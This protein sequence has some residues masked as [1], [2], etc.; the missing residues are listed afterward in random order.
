MDQPD[1]FHGVFTH[2]IG[3]GGR[4]LGR[5]LPGPATLPDPETGRQLRIATVELSGAICPSCEQHGEAGFISFVADLRLAF[6]CPNCL[7][8]IWITG[9]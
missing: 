8:L 5:P 1:P 6:A 9:A 4:R 2:E 7:E 3:P